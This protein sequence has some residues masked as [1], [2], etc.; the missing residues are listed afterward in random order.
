MTTSELLQS[1]DIISRNFEAASGGLK[2]IAKLVCPLVADRS[3]AEAV[4]RI[5]KQARDVLA[6]TMGHIDSA[7]TNIDGAL[8]MFYRCLSNDATQWHMLPTRLAAFR[9]HSRHAKGLWPQHRLYLNQELLSSLSGQFYSLDSVLPHAALWI[10]RLT[11][12]E[13]FFPRLQAWGQLP[14]LIADICAALD[15]IPHLLDKVATYSADMGDRLQLLAS[16]PTGLRDAKMAL[17]ALFQLSASWGSQF[18]RLHTQFYILKKFEPSRHIPPSLR[19][20]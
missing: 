12:S 13:Q 4:C 1:G 19:R 9:D 5:I 15:P 10:A 18:N 17:P 6:I 2:E 20:T 8:I 16:S 3:E 11:R 14:N 7:M